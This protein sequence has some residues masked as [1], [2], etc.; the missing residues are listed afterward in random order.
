MKKIICRTLCLIFALVMMIPIVSGCNK[1]KTDI[2]ILGNH[3]ITEKEYVY[4]TG[5]FKKRVMMSIDPYLTDND[6]TQEMENGMTIAEYL[7]IAYR[8]SFDQTVLS[9]LFAQPMFEKLGLSLSYEDELK[10]SSAANEVAMTIAYEFSGKYDIN[11]FNKVATEYGFDYDTLVSVY[12]KQYKEAMVKEHLLG[13]NYEKITKEQKESYCKENYLCYQTLI[14]NTTYKEYVDSS[15]EKSILPLTEDEKRERE[16]LVTELKELLINKNKDY[17][18]VLLA[19]KVDMTYEQ[20]WELYDDDNRITG[21][22]PYGCYGPSDPTLAQL[23]S[24]NVLSSAY[25]SKEG[26][27]KAATAKRYFDQG[28]SFEDA[29]GETTT[30]NPGDYFEY[31]TIFVKRLPLDP[32]AYEKEENDD[33]FGDSFI[34]AVAN[35]VYFKA[36]QEYEASLSYETQVSET[37]GNFTFAT[38]KANE[39]DYYF[40]NQ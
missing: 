38:V 29:N 21:H 33:F 17:N 34:F 8:Q 40:L 31:G 15:G 23:E 2:Y 11:E 12:R 22:Y 39:L 25:Y 7:E 32:K 13:K 27:V 5:M 19:D 14:I 6:L 36:L 4:L 37:K 28:G 1:K 20:L 30:I 24:N 26:E 3:T 9:L 35:T 18:Y 10:I 16:L